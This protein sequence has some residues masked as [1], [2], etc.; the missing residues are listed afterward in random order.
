MQHPNWADLSQVIID[1][2]HDLSFATKG[3]AELMV[4]TAQFPMSSD[5]A[6][7]SDDVKALQ[8]FPSS[9]GGP[10]SVDALK[11]LVIR[12]V[13]IACAPCPILTKEACETPYAEAH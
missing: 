3:A 12:H 13:H 1:L 6:L 4:P 2:L 11:R 5:T 9:W 10:R 7:G 8:L